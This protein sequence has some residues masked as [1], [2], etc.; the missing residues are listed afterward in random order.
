M[1]KDNKKFVAGLTALAVFA[2]GAI[3]ETKISRNYYKVKDS[4]KDVTEY[5]CDN[6]LLDEVDEDISLID[7]VDQLETYLDIVDDLENKNN[8][9]QKWIDENG[10][11][12]VI[13]M[14]SWT[15]KSLV[16]EALDIPTKDIDKVEMPPTKKVTGM[17]FYVT[18]NGQKYRV[19]NN[20]SSIANTLF[21]YYQVKVTEDFGIYQND[22]Y[23]EAINCSKIANMTGLEEK[24]NKLGNKTKYREAKKELKRK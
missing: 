13:D 15:T 23:K 18:Y 2:G 20:N 6:T 14:L 21:Y 16:A 5:F 3:C 11:E 24:Y 8:E 1:T 9:Y 22:I 12:I 10:K 17:V 4:F 19:T 7:R